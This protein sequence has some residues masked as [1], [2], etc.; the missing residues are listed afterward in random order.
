MAIR[1]ITV[2]DLGD[3]KDVDVIEV[4]VKVGDTIKKDDI[5]IVVEG[6]KATMDVPASLGGVVT[7]LKIKVG[8]KVSK[9]TLVLLVDDAGSA[10]AAAPQATAAPVAAS[11]VAPVV[12]PV[13]APAAA[14]ASAP[15]APATAASQTINVPDI[16]DAKDVD[17][18]EIS[19]KPGD[20][21]NKDDTLIVVE[22]E[23]ATMEVPSPVSGVVESIAL[24]VGDKVSKGSL[25]G[26]LKVAGATAAASS[27]APAP[28]ASVAAA[29]AP[30]PATTA[31]NVVTA[32]MPV[33]HAGR[34]APVPDYPVER[35]VGDKIVHASPSVRRFARELGVDLARVN[36]SGEKGRVLKEDVQGWVKFELSRPK[37]VAASVGGAPELPDVDHA[38]WGPIETKSLSRIQKV[39]AVNLHRN[40]L[41]IPHVTQHDDADITE[42]EAFRQSLKDEA[43]KRGVK[44][45]P[46]AFVT[47]AL[48]NSLQAFPTFN[49]SLQ[50]DGETLVLKK[51]Y[52]I[53]IA[54]DTPDGL[55]VPVIRDVDKKSVFD[56]AA[57]MADIS[58]K[59]R[60][61]KLG[62][63]GMAGSTFTI[64]SLG[65]IGGTYFTPIVAW[66]NVAILGLSKSSMKPV[67]DGSQFVPRLMLPMSLSY[68]HRVID[69][70]VGARFITHLSKNLADIR[71]LLL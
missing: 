62:A 22:G 2:P 46:L 12:A 61:K 35:R 19:V 67:W 43:E 29:A 1:E 28:A 8:D 45:T 47:K 38:K 56:I 57:D 64:S 58:K 23:K 26:V 33:E 36:G 20:S 60:E 40:W 32:V 11:V 49:A 69:G 59:A 31:S 66:P 16:G 34:E 39:S 30:V 41:V 53:G 70:A 5:I 3:V 4:P 25:I 24:K 13:A 51:H 63:D 48:V 50:K 27:A 54:V 9:G 15:Q 42:L 10:A 18:I 52:H 6:E 7:E 65:G 55:V 71:R 21:V 17:V 14:P 68:D 37:P 44:L